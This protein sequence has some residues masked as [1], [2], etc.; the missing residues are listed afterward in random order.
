MPG[1]PSAGGSTGSGARGTLDYYTGELGEKLLA[2]LEEK[3]DEGMFG[4]VQREMGMP[5]AAANPMAVAAPATAP[6]GGDE[7]GGEP[8]ADG[9]APA[10]PAGGNGK[11]QPGSI[12]PGITFV[13]MAS[14][15]EALEKMAAE[16]GVD[17][18]ITYDVRIQ[19]A[20]NTK[21]VNNT[22]KISFNLVERPNE[23]PI[24]TSAALTNVK[25]ATEREKS[26]DGDPVDDEIEKLIAKLESFVTP[27]GTPQTLKVSPFL[28]ALTPQHAANR[29]INL[30]S[31]QSE[32]PLR[33]LAEIKVYHA[34]KLITDQQF[35]D[36]AKVFLKDKAELLAKGKESERKEAVAALLPRG[37]VKR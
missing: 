4:D 7:P 14:S 11:D 2:K 8:G 29:V 13:G 30:T 26:K 3:V 24:H 9:A 16:Q 12:R 21:I 6:P 15:R 36:A 27:T 20:G 33:D 31:S 37:P 5:T 22:T 35:Q 1:M 34:K 18:L 28:D 10:A 17:V 25:V 23:V 19:R 32:F